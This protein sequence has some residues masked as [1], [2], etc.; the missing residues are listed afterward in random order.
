MSIWPGGCG[1]AVLAGTAT[2]GGVWGISVGVR[3]SPTFAEFAAV[4]QKAWLR[5]AYLL[6][7]DRV[8]AQDLAQETA[9]RVLAGWRKVVRADDPVAYSR[10]IMLHLYLGGHRRRWHGEVATA[11]LPEVA[12][13][14]AYRQLDDR[15]VVRRALQEL[16]ARQRA[17][18]VLR[19]VE[20]LSETE[21]AQVLG[22]SVGTV[23]SLTSRGTATLRRV[24]SAQEITT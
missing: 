8:T 10:R 13:P 17:A 22:C 21:T 14:D 24:L 2:F 7:G 18:V 16:P 12:G 5:S 15:D 19:R 9:V 6:T 4:H 3:P 1:A 20:D 11:E 23:K